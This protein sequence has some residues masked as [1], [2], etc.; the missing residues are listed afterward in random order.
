MIVKTELERRLYV[1]LRRIAK[2]YQSSAYL[3]K[4]GECGLPGPE[5]LEYAY[6]NIQAEAAAAIRGVRVPRN[7]TSGDSGH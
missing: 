6:D 7:T 3:L 5:V 4:H 1:A 2:E